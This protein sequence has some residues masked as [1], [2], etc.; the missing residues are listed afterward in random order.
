LGHS[1][2][3]VPLNIYAHLMTPTNQEA[4]RRLENTV[5]GPTGHNLVTVNK[6]GPRSKT[7]T[8]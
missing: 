5:F 8:P 7:I 4:A 1:T 6:K 3:T 2:P